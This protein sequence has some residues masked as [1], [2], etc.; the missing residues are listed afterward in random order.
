LFVRS[1]VRFL[2]GFSSLVKIWRS[3]NLT[4][5]SE[6]ISRPV[7]LFLLICAGQL[8]LYLVLIISEK[9]RHH[10]APGGPLTPDF[11]SLVFYRPSYPEWLLYRQATNVFAKNLLHLHSIRISQ[12]NHWGI[13]SL[14]L[15]R[16]LNY[17]MNLYR[18]TTNT[19]DFDIRTSSFSRHH[20]MKT[21]KV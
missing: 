8:K 16:H 20:G 14:H 4:S 2:C 19:N 12:A 18:N 9:V 15:L 7:N 17:V 13:K 5:I 1:I 6:F 3:V 11:K 21:N 10:F